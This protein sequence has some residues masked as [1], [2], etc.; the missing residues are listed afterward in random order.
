M[1][2]IANYHH[3]IELLAVHERHRTDDAIPC[4]L[5]ASCHCDRRR[6]SAHA[7]SRFPESLIGA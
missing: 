2:D 3:P 5:L 4:D 7:S 1:M 6:S